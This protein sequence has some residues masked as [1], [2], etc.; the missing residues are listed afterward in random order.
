[1]AA[2]VEGQAQG[3]FQVVVDTAKGQDM[4]DVAP[5]GQPVREK[6]FQ[7]RTIIKSGPRLVACIIAVVD[8]H[9]PGAHRQEGDQLA[10]RHEMIQPLDPVVVN[11]GV[12]VGG[13][14]LGVDVI[15]DRLGTPVL[16]EI[17]AETQAIDRTV[18]Q[19]LIS[20]KPVSPHKGG[21]GK[22]PRPDFGQGG[23][24]EGND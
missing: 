18:L 4:P 19:V 24:T 2:E 17:I 14:V 5:E 6:V 21:Y 11:V 1:V 3:V 12:G 22:G 16:R 8:G 9:A 23:C 13:L 7:A 20:F 10:V 15:K